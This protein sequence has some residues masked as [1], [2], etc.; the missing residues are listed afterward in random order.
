VSTTIRP[1]TQVAEVA[2]NKASTK[3]I[4]PPL[5][6][7]GSISKKLPVRIVNT[8]LKV[9]TLAGWKIKIDFLLF[10]AMEFIR[11]IS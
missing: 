11:L 4:D 1:V 3:L 9:R 7:I 8:K 5:V 6:E 2:V 10:F